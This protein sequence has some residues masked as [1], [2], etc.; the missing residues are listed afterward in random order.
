MKTIHPQTGATAAPERIKLRG[1]WAPDQPEL[2]AQFIAEHEKVLT[3]IGVNNIVATEHHWTTD[4]NCYVIV[5]IHEEQGMVGGIRLQLAV[6]GVNLPMVDAIEKAHPNVHMAMEELLPWGNGEVC[7]LWAAHRFLGK[8]V[9]TLLSKAVTT[10]SVA[11][12]AGR[13]VCFVAHYTQKYPAQNGFIVMENV[14][15]NGFFPAYPIPRI[16]TIAMVNPDTMLLE[17][18]SQQQR[19]SI[20][21]LRLRPEQTRMEVFGNAM[22]EVE[23][24][25]RVNTGV[26]DLYAYQ[27]IE[28]YRRMASA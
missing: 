28:S 4:P 6:K 5:A 18:A 7:G 16:T 20:Y 3:D 26:H 15:E 11:A 19:Q 23:Y 14:G 13:M 22:L 24:D 17:H 21:S 2:C 25:L 27:Q 10:I 8:G 9:P 1:F 12:G